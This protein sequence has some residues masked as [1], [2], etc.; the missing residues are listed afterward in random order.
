MKVV[1]SFARKSSKNKL[2]IE[3]VDTSIIYINSSM[4]LLRVRNHERLIYSKVLDNRT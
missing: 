3:I 4:A 1:Q 2:C